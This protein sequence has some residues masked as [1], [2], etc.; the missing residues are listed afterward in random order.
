MLGLLHLGHDM[1]SHAGIC[2]GGV[3]AT[4]LDE[5]LGTLA[6]LRV[7]RKNPES[8]GSVTA[9]LN[10]DYVKPVGVPGAVMVKARVVRED[11]RKVYVDGEIVAIPYGAP[12]GGEGE[13]QDGEG[14][15][16]VCTKGRG[17]FVKLRD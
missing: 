17:L 4:I 16:E 11:G 3:L 14:R 8:R 9:N 1:A 13:D 2:H 10:V 12:S 7:K 5:I 15:E 6:F